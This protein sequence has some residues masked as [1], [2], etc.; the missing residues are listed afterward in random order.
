MFPYLTY[1]ETRAFAVISFLKQ[2]LNL[3]TAPLLPLSF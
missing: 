1:R 3:A 2:S